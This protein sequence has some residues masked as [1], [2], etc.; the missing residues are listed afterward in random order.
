MA[1]RLVTRAI[2]LSAGDEDSNLEP[3]LALARRLKAETDS[4]LRESPVPPPVEAALRAILFPLSHPES[5]SEDLTQQLARQLEAEEKD[6]AWSQFEERVKARA[7]SNPSRDAQV[8]WSLFEQQ[9]AQSERD[10]AVAEKAS[11]NLA[12]KLGEEQRLQQI[13]TRLPS[14][15]RRPPPSLSVARSQ[16]PTSVR[17]HHLRAVDT[18]AQMARIEAEWAC[19]SPGTI[20]GTADGVRLCP[21]DP[22]GGEF[23]SIIELFKVGGLNPDALVSIV[24]VQHDLLHQVHMSSIALM[25]ADHRPN[26]MFM[27]HGARNNDQSILESGLEPMYGN[28]K[29][30]GVWL[31]HMADY[32][33]ASFASTHDDGTKTMFLVR[34][35]TGV[36]GRDDGTGR[37]ARPF[38]EEETLNSGVRGAG[39]KLATCHAFSQPSFVDGRVVMYDKGLTFPA[40][41]VRFF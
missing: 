18:S 20:S 13:M 7:R 21:L 15:M 2:E 35:A 24:R 9:V 3:S 8:A 16:V 41:V 25:P 33:A 30:Y 6:K 22:T 5:V 34:A 29:P 17:R 37:R 19:N 11:E 39:G 31:H 4:A 14:D 36:H 23:N 12:R 1:A 40:Y 28:S 27:W 10:A 32:S 26:I 38:G